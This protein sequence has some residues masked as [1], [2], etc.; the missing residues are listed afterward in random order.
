MS[1]SAWN[2]PAACGANTAF[3]LKTQPLD[4]TGTHPLV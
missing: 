1:I 3:T 2:E 4:A